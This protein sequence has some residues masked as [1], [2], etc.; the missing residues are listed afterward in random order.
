MTRRTPPP[1]ARPRH[2]AALSLLV[3]ALGT[4]NSSRVWP[5]GSSS[6]VPGLDRL[7]IP[8]A[9]A[10]A[11]PAPPLRRLAGAGSTVGDDDLREVI[12][13][14]PY[15]FSALGLLVFADAGSNATAKIPPTT[16]GAESSSD[17]EGA[18]KKPSGMSICTG[19]MVGPD[20][21]VTAAHCIYSVAGTNDDGS[22]RASGLRKVLG[23]FPSYARTESGNGNAP[24]GRVEA[25]W[26]DVLQDWKD[27]ADRGQ[28][29]W[30]GD[31]GIV[32][33]AKPVGDTT[34]WFGLAGGCAVAA[35]ALR[36]TAKERAGS[37]DAETSATA[38]AVAGFPGSSMVTGG[39]KM[40]FPLMGDQRCR[41]SGSQL[42]PPDAGGEPRMAGMLRHGCDTGKGMS[43]APMWLQDATEEASVAGEIAASSG[44]AGALPRGGSFFAGSNQ[45][46][47][48][49]V[50]VVSRHYGDCPWGSDCVNLA[51]PLDARAVDF[52]KARVNSQR[53]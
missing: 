49:A 2:L 13:P 29:Y 23:F 34:G 33:L 44:F 21:V 39:G 31:V 3:I 17:P 6:G 26:A 24:L 30:R 43:G 40:Y 11:A 10:A 47:A 37:A 45:R 38:A 27:Y 20:T 50:G 12:S 41:L 28:F 8:A 25:L 19:W 52:L 18:K 9:A 15:P 22:A 42:C 16:L 36:Y 46:P 53:R 32:R 48:V 35:K 14:L 5:L 1:G 7:A 4:A 51:A